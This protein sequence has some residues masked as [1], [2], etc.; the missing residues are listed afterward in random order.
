MPNDSCSVAR[1]GV[2]QRARRSHFAMGFA[3]YEKGGYGKGYGYGFSAAKSS[4]Q[5][6]PIL[7]LAT[8]PPSRTSEGFMF[9]MHLQ[10]GPCARGH[11]GLFQREP[12]GL[13]ASRVRVRA[14]EAGAT[15]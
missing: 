13:L 12:S 2:R 5:F 7:I 9:K 14:P 8:P 6:R 4:L 11:V 15:P 10:R 1:S 3:G